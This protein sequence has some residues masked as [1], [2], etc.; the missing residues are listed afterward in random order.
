[1]TTYPADYLDFS[2]ESWGRIHRGHN[3]NLA[4]LE[5]DLRGS[6]VG[7][8]GG[9]MVVEEVHLR[10]RPRLKW[11]GQMFGFPCDDEGD[12]HAH[13]EAVQPGADTAFTTVWW[14]DAEAV[15]D[16][17]GRCN[18]NGGDGIGAGHACSCVRSVGHPLDDA[19]PHGCN[20][21]A[22]WAHESQ[23]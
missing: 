11:C 22:L 9:R 5:A 18:H 12:W 20:C 2:T 19:R 3:L 16:A 8:P 7:D 15:G 23:E 21:G 13:W 4:D 17:V 6:R 14:T 1:M 10:Y